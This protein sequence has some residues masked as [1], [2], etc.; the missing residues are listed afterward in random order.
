MHP[1]SGLT[2]LLAGCLLLAACS[3]PGPGPRSAVAAQVKGPDSS[4]KFPTFDRVLLLET[5]A[6]T[7]ANVSAGDVNGDGNLDL[8]LAKGRIGR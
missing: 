6:E 5:T 2:Q 7:S 8:V 1:R 3:A 4:L